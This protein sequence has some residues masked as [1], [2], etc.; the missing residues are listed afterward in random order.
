MNQPPEKKKRIVTKREYVQEQAGRLG[1]GCLGMGLMIGAIVCGMISL[2]VLALVMAGQIIAYLVGLAN[3]LQ[4]DP[5][6]NAQVP[7]LSRLLQVAATVT[8]LS[9]G[10]FAMPLR[11]LADSWRVLP[12]GQGL[13]SGAAAEAIAGAVGASFGLA[14]RLAGPFVLL[15]VGWQVAFALLGRLVPRLQV[16]FIA[17]PGQ[18]LL[19]LLLFALLA[20]PL[21]AVW[22]E[23]VRDQFALLPGL[24]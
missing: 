12:P 8:V 1:F 10:L 5:G 22:R 2:A 15:S 20:A 16:F 3:V 19:G 11:A 4:L 14:L 18:I 23:A 24:G 21:L 9:S 13:P 6:L 17:A 7:A